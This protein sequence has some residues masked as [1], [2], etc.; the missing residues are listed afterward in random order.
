MSKTVLRIA[1]AV[2]AA[3]YL[4]RVVFSQSERRKLEETLQALEDAT[5]GSSLS[6]G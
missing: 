1:V 3:V 5:S 6:Q 2:G 4:A